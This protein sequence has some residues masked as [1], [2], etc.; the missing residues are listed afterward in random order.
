MSKAKDVRASSSVMEKLIEDQGIQVKQFHSG[1]LVEG[2]VISVS[3]DQ[4]LLDIAQKPR[5]LYLGQKWE[6]CEHYPC[7]EAR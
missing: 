5:A 6:K 1:E 3:H 2:L 7:L 4:V